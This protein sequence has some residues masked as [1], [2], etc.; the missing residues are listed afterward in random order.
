MKRLE[1]VTLTIDLERVDRDLAATF[2]AEGE[3]F[4]TTHYVARRKNEDESDIGRVRQIAWLGQLDFH[5]RHDLGSLCESISE[6]LEAMASVGTPVDSIF[7]GAASGP[8]TDGLEEVVYPQ[9]LEAAC[10]SSMLSLTDL[11]LIHI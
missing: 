2:A 1:L 10:R 5:A 3:R 4:L 6:L 11:S 9:G 8:V 7:T